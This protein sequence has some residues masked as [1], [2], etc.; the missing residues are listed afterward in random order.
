MG[1][2]RELAEQ[3]LRIA[4]DIRRDDI[5]HFEWTASFDPE[6]WRVTLYLTNGRRLVYLIYEEKERDTPSGESHLW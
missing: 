6:V 5:D 1:K 2:A 4:G 3:A